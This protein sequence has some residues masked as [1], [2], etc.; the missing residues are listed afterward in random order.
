MLSDYLCFGLVCP[1][2]AHSPN[3]RCSFYSNSSLHLPPRK[4]QKEK[5]SNSS[6]PRRGGFTIHHCPIKWHQWSR[7]FSIFASSH[8]L[9][10]EPMLRGDDSILIAESYGKILMVRVSETWL[11]WS[12]WKWKTWVIRNSIF[13]APGGIWMG[14]QSRT[15]VLYDE[16][17]LG[18]N[19]LTFLCTSLAYSWIRATWI[20]P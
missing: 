1:L 12:G 2:M 4:P 10:F 13:Y 16:I 20:T 15:I 17:E 3:R 5:E 19:G 9:M 7:T 11:R 6:V 18:S 14:N 8:L